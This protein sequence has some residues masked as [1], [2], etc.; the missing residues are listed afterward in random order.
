MIVRPVVDALVAEIIDKQID[1]MAIDP[2]VSCHEL[3]ENDNTA[4]D[5]A[6]KEWGRVA[7]LRQLRGPPRRPHPQDERLRKPR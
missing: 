4:Q 7:E 2:F 1:V 5:M 3:P 6:V